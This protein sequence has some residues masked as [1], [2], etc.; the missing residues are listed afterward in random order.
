MVHS[1]EEALDREYAYVVVTTKSLP[2]VHPVEKVLKP[3]IDAKKAKT[4]V[5]I[6]VSPALPTFLLR[7]YRVLILVILSTRTVSGLKKGFMA[8]PAQSTLPS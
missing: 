6:Q 5:L 1:I 8:R 7:H 4:F 2:D 3:I